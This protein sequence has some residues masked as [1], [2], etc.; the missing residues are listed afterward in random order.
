MAEQADKNVKYSQRDLRLKIK[1][2]AKSTLK[3]NYVACIVVCFIML[4]AGGEYST[5]TQQITS[6]DNSHVTD[7]QY[8]GEE[9][10]YI[11]EDM[12]KN[13]L[14]P[15]EASD[16]WAV[17]DETAVKQWLESYDKYGPDSLNSSDVAFLGASTGSSNFSNLMNTFATT[18]KVKD[19]ATLAVNSRLN[20]ATASLA[21]YFDGVTK[22]NTYQFKFVGTF[23]SVLSK[24]TTWDILV[25][26]IGFLAE[27]MFSVFIVNILIV[28]ERRF[29]LES[30]TYKKTKPGRLGFLFREHIKGPAKTMFVKDIFYALWSLTIVGGFVKFYSYAMVPYI[31]A[32]NPNIKPMKA[33]SLSRK[34]MNHHK[35]EMFKID[36]TLVG[37]VLLSSITFGLGGI[38]FGNPYR[39]AVESEFYIHLRRLAIENKTEGYEEFTDKYLDLDLLQEQM[40]KEAVE[41]GE[42]PD[43]V[44]Y[45]PIFKIETADAD[46]E[47]AE[48][49]FDKKQE[50]SHKEDE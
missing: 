37:W 28:G 50:E 39:T 5:S 12:K 8:S 30:R 38:F 45:K 22:N 27:L 24:K 11:V 29:F 43:V 32:E 6:Y 18:K 36:V 31:V 15:K 46:D 26:L 42:N 9:K 47:N 4:F 1:K 33:I 48:T 35:W 14:T 3:K 41:N 2:N 16:K 13:G 23:M 49:N 19:D 17:E 25:Q 7:L 40:E 44:H 20:K 34:M 10:I 21:S